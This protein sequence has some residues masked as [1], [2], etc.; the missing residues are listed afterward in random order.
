MVR[1]AARHVDGGIPGIELDRPIAIPQ[2]ILVVLHPRVNR[3]ARQVQPRVLRI[4]LDGFAVVRHRSVVLTQP[5]AHGPS[6]APGAHIL[7]LEFQRRREVLAGAPIV[8]G[9]GV[10]QRALH[11]RLFVVGLDSETLVEIVDG[12]AVLPQLRVRHSAPHIRLRIVQ[13]EFNGLREVLDGVGVLRRRQVSVAARR[14]NLRTLEFQT[15]GGAVVEDGAVGLIGG[16]E[17]LPADS[18]RFGVAGLKLDGLVEIGRGLFVVARGQV[19]LAARAPRRLVGG[20]RLDRLR[21]RGNSLVPPPRCVGA[22]PALILGLRPFLVRLGGRAV[23]GKD[24][25]RYGD[26]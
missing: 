10:R 2:G 6:H 8:S 24:Q 21:V 20:V 22:N 3:A 17:E 11:Q 19:V 9:A 15:D 4:A 16:G 23:N 25:S 26:G 13:P 12:V 5:L 1:A 18:V 7:G 14:I